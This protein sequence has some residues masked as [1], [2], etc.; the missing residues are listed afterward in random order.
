MEEEDKSNVHS[1][2]QNKRAYVK[3][4]DHNEKNERNKRQKNRRK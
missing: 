4:D 2:A 1:P 3:D